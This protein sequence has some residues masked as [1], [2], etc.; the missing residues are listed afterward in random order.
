M[1]SLSN[2][3]GRAEFTMAASSGLHVPVQQIKGL[4]IA[5]IFKTPLIFLQFFHDLRIQYPERWS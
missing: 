2:T 5:Q 4:F 1:Q 3:V